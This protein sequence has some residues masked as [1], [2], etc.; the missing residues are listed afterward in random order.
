MQVRRVVTGTDADGRSI[1]TSDDSE[2]TTGG[3]DGGVIWIWSTT[4]MPPELDGPDPTVQ[5]WKLQ[6]PPNGIN[7]QLV[8]CPAGG[9]RTSMH[10]TK[11]VD[12]VMIVSGEIWLML[13]D[14]E[15]CL[16]PYESVIQRATTHAW[17]NRGTEP[18]VMLVAMISTEV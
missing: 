14:Q 7:W 5:E 11:S 10:E 1:V 13:D 9:E 17:Q 12:L 6:P 16:G 3:T 15:V 2:R 4:A 8:V 18:A